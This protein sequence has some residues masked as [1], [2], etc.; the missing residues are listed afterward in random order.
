MG[1]KSEERAVGM[2]KK[3]KNEQGGD[4]D[5]HELKFGGEI[6]VVHF[7]AKTKVERGQLDL[8]RARFE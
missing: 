7:P 8:A 2:R 3:E 5:S 4:V 6:G 1:G